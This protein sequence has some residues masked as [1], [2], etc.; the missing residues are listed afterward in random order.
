MK[1]VDN[2]EQNSADRMKD[3]ELEDIFNKYANNYGIN[4]DKGEAQKNIDIES[5]NIKS[6]IRMLRFQ[7]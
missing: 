6:K 2:L 7:N 3:N 5:C 1:E 4:Y